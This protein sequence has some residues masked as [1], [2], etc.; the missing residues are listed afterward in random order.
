[1]QL[2]KIDQDGSVVFSFNEDE[3]LLINN[4]VLIAWDRVKTNDDFHALAGVSRSRAERFLDDLRKLET[5]AGLRELDLRDSDG[6]S[7]T[8]E[9]ARER[10]DRSAIDPQKNDV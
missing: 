10:Y 1:M 4:G 2:L 7:L 9:Q 8:E 5:Q 3:R 6:N